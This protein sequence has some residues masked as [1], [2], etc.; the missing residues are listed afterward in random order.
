M[1]EAGGQQVLDQIVFRTPIVLGEGGQG[2][3]H[4][5][6]DH[7]Y[8]RGGYG[9]QA[10]HGQNPAPD[11]HGRIVIEQVFY[12]QSISFIFIRRVVCRVLVST[13]NFGAFLVGLIFSNFHELFSEK[14]QWVLKSSK[15]LICSGVF[16]L[17]NKNRVCFAL[18]LDSSLP[19]RHKLRKLV[20]PMQDRCQDLPPA[21]WVEMKIAIWQLRIKSL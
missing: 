15:H 10:Y 20:M 14:Q 18:L 19:T 9:T 16:Q 4:T 5:F 7:V 2:D 11:R 8:T 1:G 3:L 21:P 17:H 13:R 6:T 12:C